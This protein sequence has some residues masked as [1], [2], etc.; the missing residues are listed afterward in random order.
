MKLNNRLFW[1]KSRFLTN[2]FSCFNAKKLVLVFFVGLFALSGLFAADAKIVAT[3]GG[4]SSSWSSASSWVDSNGNSVQAPIN[5]GDD[6]ILNAMN[7]AITLTLENDLT[8]TDL[9]VYGEK[10]VTINL[11]GRKLTVNGSIFIGSGPGHALITTDEANC[12]GNLTF[13]NGS[14]VSNVMNTTSYGDPAK[15]PNLTAEQRK[16]VLTIGDGETSFDVNNCWYVGDYTEAQITNPGN[17]QLNITRNIDGAPNFVKVLSDQL[18]KTLGIPENVFYWTGTIDNS[19]SKSGNWKDKEGN[20]VSRYPSEMGDVAVFENTSDI[21]ITNFSANDNSTIYFRAPNSTGTITFANMQNTSSKKIFVESGKYVLT[22]AIN[23]LNVAEGAEVTFTGGWLELGGDLRNEG[24]VNIQANQVQV[25]N[26]IINKG[27]INIDNNC[28]FKINNVY[29]NEG[30]NG[31]TIKSNG[32]T[33]SV[34]NNVTGEVVISK[35]DATAIKLTGTQNARIKVLSLNNNSVGNITVQHTELSTGNYESI[36]VDNAP[37]YITGAVTVNGNLTAGWNDVVL[38]EGST[39]TV[40]DSLSGKIQLKDGS[41]CAFNGFIAGQ[42]ISFT[43]YKNCTIEYIGTTNGEITSI[44]LPNNLEN[45][46]EITIKSEKSVVTLNQGVNSNKCNLILEGKVNLGTDGSNQI[47]N[48]K[49]L[50]CKE[51]STIG[52]NGSITVSENLENNGTVIQNGTLAINGNFASGDSLSTYA[53]VILEPT[54][55]AVTVSGYGQITTLNSGNNLGG[56]TINFN[57]NITITGQ[58]SNLKGSGNENKL[59]IGGTG[60]ITVENENAISTQYL[61][62]LSSSSPIVKENY[63]KVNNSSAPNGIFPAGWIDDKTYIW[64]GAVSDYLPEAGNWKEG[65]VPPD[66]DN[67]VSIIVTKPTESSNPFVMQTSNNKQYMINF[68]IEE[69]AEAQIPAGAFVE[70]TGGCTN[71]GTLTNSGELT[72]KEILSSSGTITNNNLITIENDFVSTGTITNNGNLFIKGNTEISGDYSGTNDSL[73][74]INQDE[75]QKTVTIDKPIS[76]ET[77]FIAGNI[78]LV[79]ND[80]VSVASFKTNAGAENFIDHN[81]TVN[82]GGTGSLSTMSTTSMDFTRASS[83]DDVI[84]TYNLNVPVTCSGEIK[85]HSG[86]VLNI[87]SNTQTNTLVHSANNANY[88]TFINVKSNAS[89]TVNET[90]DLAA[91]ANSGASLSVES[92]ATVKAKSIIDTSTFANGEGQIP[93]TNYGTIEVSESIDLTTISNSGTITVP[94]INSSSLT[95]A[96]TITAT[97]AFTA[98]DYLRPTDSTSDVVNIEEGTTLSIENGTISTLNVEKTDDETDFATISSTGTLTISSATYNNADIQTNGTG[99]I[100]LANTIDSDSIGNLTIESGELTIENLNVG[101]LTNKA[102]FSSSTVN[103]TGNLT[104]SGTSFAGTINFVGNSD[105]IFTPNTSTTSTYGDINIGDGTS[106]STTIFAGNV[107]AGVISINKNAK[108]QTN[109]GEIDAT[110]FDVKEGAELILNNATVTTSE[111]STYRGLSGTGFTISA[112]ES[113]IITIDQ[114]TVETTGNQNYF[115]SVKLSNETTFKS[116]GTIIFGNATTDAF[117]K[118]GD[119]AP[120][121]ILQAP[122]VIYGNSTIDSITTSESL[123]LVDNNTINNLSVTTAGGKTLA[124]NGEITVDSLSLSGTSSESLLQID[125]SGSFNLTT[126]PSESEIVGNYL[127][128]VNPTTPTEITNEAKIRNSKDSV[129]GITSFPL[130]WEYDNTFTWTGATSNNWNV[131]TNWDQG[132]VPNETS[133][134]IIPADKKVIISGDFTHSGKITN[135]GELTF[136]ENAGPGQTVTDVYTFTNHG[137][138]TNSGKIKV[139]GNLTNSSSATIKNIGKLEVGLEAGPGG[140]A[141]PTCTFANS[142]SL[143]NAQN[144]SNETGVIKIKGTFDN[145]NGTVTN[146]AKI[147]LNSDFD[148]NKGTYNEVGILSFE[149]K[150]DSVSIIEL[151]P[152]DDNKTLI[153]IEAKNVQLKINGKADIN[154]FVNDN[155]IVEIPTGSNVSIQN[156][157]PFIPTDGPDA[158]QPREKN[159]L[160]IYEGATV[161]IKND[162]T[163]TN[164]TVQTSTDDSDF[165]YIITKNLFVTNATYNTA[166]IKTKGNITLPETTETTNEIGNLEIESGNLT[167]RNLIANKVS[168]GGKLSASGSVTITT[169]LSNTGTVETATLSVG[170][171]ISNNAV[172]KTT[173]TNVG[174]NLTDNG[175]SFEGTINFVGTS[176]QTFSPNASTAYGDINIGD[177]TSASI[178]TITNDLKAGIVTI[179]NNST[180]QTNDSG[181]TNIEIT[182]FDIEEGSQLILNGAMVTTSDA[183]TYRGLSGTFFFISAGTNSITIDQETVQTTA[184]QVYESPVILTKDT[185]FEITVNGN[186]LVFEKPITTK[187]NSLTAK[188]NEGDIT[189]GSENSEAFSDK[190]TVVLQGPATIYG[191]NEFA[192]IT[193]NDSL[194]FKN[195]NTVETLSVTNAGG[196]TLTIDGQITVTTME[197]SGTNTD[198]LLQIDG[199]GKFSFTAEPSGNVGTYLKF[200]NKESPMVVIPDKPNGMDILTDSL[201]HADGTTEFPSGW[202]EII[203]ENTRTWEG[204]VSSDWDKPENWEEG[205][206]PNEESKVVIPVV[207]EGNNYPVT[208]ETDVIS[209]KSLIVESS[210]EITLNNTLTATDGITN[211]GTINL[212]NDYTLSC[213]ITNKGKINA[214]NSVVIQDGVQLTNNKN[215]DV[216]G[217]L[218]IETGAT[219]ENINNSNNRILVYGDL[220]IAGSYS[221]EGTIYFANHTKEHTITNSANDTAITSLGIVGTQ[222]NFVCDSPLTIGTLTKEE[223]TIYLQSGSLSVGTYS[224]D[225]NIPAE[226][227]ILKLNEGATISFTN[228]V[229]FNSVEIIN[230][231]DSSVAKINA[232]DFTTETLN[233]YGD[234]TNENTNAINA[235]TMTVD[236]NQADADSNV[237]IGGN[238]SV[239]TFNCKEQGGKSLEVNGEINMNDMFISGTK[240]A[241]TDETNYLTLQGTGSFAYNDENKTQFV[242]SYLKFTS[243]TPTVSKGHAEITSSEHNG[244]AFPTGWILPSEYTWTGKGVKVI[245]EIVPQTKWGADQ[246]WNPEGQ[247]DKNSKVKIPVVTTNYPKFGSGAGSLIEM[248]S[249]EIAEGAKITVANNSS[250]ETF[251]VYE[252][253]TNDGNISNTEDGSSPFAIW[254]GGNLANNS[255][256]T[257]NTNSSIEVHGEF[258]NN[259]AI[260]GNNYSISAYGNVSLLGGYIT[261]Y[262][263]FN[264]I[265]TNSR[266]S[267][268]FYVD[269]SYTLPSL[270][271]QQGGFDFNI[272]D[273]LT[274]ETLT[275]DGMLNVRKGT[276]KVPTYEGTGAICAYD[277]T[278]TTITDFNGSGNIYLFKGSNLTITNYAGT[279]TIY[280]EEG[281]T[282]T[283][284]NG[285]TIPNLVIQT[286]TDETDFATISTNGNIINSS[287]TYNSGDIKTVGNFI[288]PSTE[289][290]TNEIGNLLIESGELTIET[291]HAENITTKENSTLKVEN[292]TITVSENLQNNGSTKAKTLTVKNVENNKEMNVETANVSGDFIDNDSFVVSTINFIGENN[293]EFLPS[294]EEIVYFEINVTKTS[295]T[296]TSTT[297]PLKVGTLNLESPENNFGEVVANSVILTNAGNTTFA[298]NVICNHTLTITNATQT[299]FNGSVEISS[300]ATTENSGKITFAKGGTI[301]TATEI[302][303]SGD[304]TFGTEGEDS[305]FIFGAEDA[306]VD[307]THTAG[308]T[309]IYGTIKAANITLAASEI[310]GNITTGDFVADDCIFDG[311]LNANN[312]TITNLNSSTGSVNLNLSGDFTNNGGTVKINKL[313]LLDSSTLTGDLTIGEFIA[314]QSLMTNPDEA[315]TLT[316]KNKLIVDSMKISGQKDENKITIANSGEIQYSTYRSFNV[317]QYI[318]FDGENPKNTNGIGLVAKVEYVNELPDGWEE[319]NTEYIWKGNDSDEWETDNNWEFGEAPLEDEEAVVIIPS[320]NITNFPVLSETTKIKYI[321]IKEG[322]TLSVNNNGSLEI[323]EVYKNLGTLINAGTVQIDFEANFAN[324]TIQN[325]GTLNLVGKVDFSQTTYTNDDNNSD[326][327]YITNDEINSAIFTTSENQKAGEIY[328]KG[329]ITSVEL[330]GNV[331]F[332]HLEIEN[333]LAVNTVTL[334][335]SNGGNLQAGSLTNKETLICN[336]NVTIFGNLIND[337]VIQIPKGISLSAN[338]YSVSSPFATSDRKVILSEGASLTIGNQESATSTIAKIEFVKTPE[339]DF[340]TISTNGNL[341]ISSTVYKINDE[342]VDIKTSGNGTIKLPSTESTTNEIGNLL[343][344]SGE[345]TIETLHA[346]NITNN[347]TL[348]A[349]TSV[350]AN[351]IEN[352]GEITSDTVLAT[353]D[354]TNDGTLTTTTSVEA[355]N[356]VN[357][358]EIT[359]PT[360]KATAELTNAEKATITA[361]KGSITVGANLTN[362]GEITSDTVLATGDLTNDG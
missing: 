247:P 39:L 43:P 73:Y 186:A 208:N 265:N 164:L 72:F 60:A 133:D 293:Q 34:G 25:N 65:R 308:K 345:L 196:K 323:T 154:K 54:G 49:S 305:T 326:K 233:V 32:G 264:L 6:A 3:E 231:D 88:Q 213:A 306:L 206:I 203:G 230:K 286:T 87:K 153:Q 77:L 121:L 292:G 15:T 347:G 21:T 273:T 75:E 171:D 28:T 4:V 259:G 350:Q 183:T 57:D 209:V 256:G 236:M 241:E 26:Y 31:G 215:I 107:T 56:K 71:S 38:E 64:T 120:K 84:G 11:N 167:I 331:S 205:S 240:N 134:V 42:N 250:V 197:L 224:Q 348:N 362:S 320:E 91:N 187:G 67:N 344:E 51:D 352:S 267:N 285:A 252:N 329:N 191:E 5:T 254:V 276:L 35:L 327:I 161:D 289:S 45:D 145:T 184:G 149:G 123:S 90:I 357:S 175:T 103:I 162:V 260:S 261:G 82:I 143:Q 178:T 356:I 37:C 12:L 50:I 220:T 83:T 86:S 140:G 24:T 355:K 30:E 68:I 330:N 61:N 338:T 166:N 81:F 2:C 229:A 33:F 109:N 115:A 227:N 106:A 172:I 340:A 80:D 112:A 168:N 225:S 332:K 92:G 279:G 235:T 313:T 211:F 41:K 96:G 303:S 324:S 281:A 95:S 322:A 152:K 104:D 304:V 47:F 137:T 111:D 275:N 102:N 192:S 221:G 216:K 202:K 218:S 207:G 214:E 334:S 193:S 156:Y 346:A 23:S 314:T 262:S 118:N 55:D 278:N 258:E 246:N 127:K 177:G 173:T 46:V 125:G 255:T 126:T 141:V 181:I 100:K 158:G 242:G 124:V 212:P 349:T 69:N 147:T 1:K 176:A 339:T 248:L 114:D 29:R 217:N 354:L 298:G 321:E 113:K 269:S 63:I 222:I 245:I 180:L 200:I 268:T 119:V 138:I 52:L 359:T 157:S 288:L 44:T 239:G 315:K 223:G 139:N 142:G 189:F 271:I 277:G 74:I 85:T 19:W 20:A 257:I 58:N 361:T 290:T 274:I 182:R 13:T 311:E 341:T 328:L 117:V 238:F 297:N 70:V 299:T 270:K 40:N 76:I 251:K 27:V 16:N 79:L 59:K 148:L 159:D 199:S 98:T 130:G 10:G 8:I 160:I 36:T 301:S 353:G 294:K 232:T 131:A 263:A 66:G 343:I 358:G 169:D 110:S 99:T 300:L 219:L 195:N 309:F 93:L 296:F 105:Q 9:F 282:L 53:S 48:I 22:A 310:N 295:G 351:N 116:G 337:Y 151:K 185:T 360:V 132:E 163:I 272:T 266:F 194:T 135:N 144:S 319:I 318:K 244:T 234:F 210:A 325:N 243:D 284:K 136:G 174:R 228:Q 18:T 190:A 342:S 122:T 249:L 146:L 237:V 62:F 317:G 198:N 287:A 283:I 150:K 78:D 335:S 170:R 307:F 14:V 302:L 94:T 97:N 108:L 291:L 201:D 188:T 128:F 7:G 204:D 226:E 101:N 17:A 165:A 336:T 312:V 280:L 333:Q 155:A 89:L 179:K 316:I 253:F 129:D